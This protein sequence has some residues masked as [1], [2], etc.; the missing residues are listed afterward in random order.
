LTSNLM[1][2][3]E[4]QILLEAIINT[5]IAANP[6]E[7]VA[8]VILNYLD[9]D[10]QFPPS[11][12]LLLEKDRQIALEKEEPLEIVWLPPRYRP[13]LLTS[14]QAI[15]ICSEVM[16]K[17]MSGNLYQM[18]EEA[19]KILDELARE[20][21]K[22]DWKGKLPTTPDFI[23]FPMDYEADS[24]I[25]RITRVLPQKRQKSLRSKGLL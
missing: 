11:I 7:P 25:E 19:N 23:A 5:V 17:I 9:M 13:I 10:G 15:Q 22:V 3:A 24:T 20:L 6:G 18:N 21:M 2:K 14:S 1:T 16:A 8:A 12:L 4:K